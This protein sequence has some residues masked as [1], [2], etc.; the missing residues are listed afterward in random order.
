VTS[1]P[2]GLVGLL[3]ALRYR[4]E[5]FRLQ[6]PPLRKRT[7]LAALALRFVRSV[8][9]GAR[10]S[11]AGLARLAAHDWPGNLHELRA[12]V[13][14]AM[15]VCPDEVLE[16]RDLDA[17]LPA[18]RD[19]PA[20]ECCAQCAGVPWKESQCHAIRAT[21]Q[22]YEGNISLAARAL[23]MSRTTIYKHLGVQD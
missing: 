20:A 18:I 19:E 15:L 8:R 14:Q 21:V 11:E 10:I 23:G 16:P 5:G 1:E 12:I 13:T 22:R 4:L 17:L 2:D 9:P 7:D 3:P 6:L